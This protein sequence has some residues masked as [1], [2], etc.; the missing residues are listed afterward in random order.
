MAMKPLRL[1]RFVGLA[2]T[3]TLQFKWQW[4]VITSN[5]RHAIFPN[6][7]AARQYKSV[8]PLELK[9]RLQRRLIQSDW[10]DYQD[11]FTYNAKGS[12]SGR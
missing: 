7:Q 10:N 1:Y 11:S 9:P 4:R 3:V 5:G 6:R 8:V 12:G 2:C